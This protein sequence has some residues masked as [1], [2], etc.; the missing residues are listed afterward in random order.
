MIPLDAIIGAITSIANP[1]IKD[2]LQRSETV[3]KLLKQF[4][5]DPEHPLP[6][7]SSVYAY[8]LVE[9]GLGKPKPILE[10]FR[11]EEI[12]QAFREAFDRN[13]PAIFLKQGEEFLHSRALGDEI[14]DLGIDIRREFAAFSAVFIAVTKR[15]RT[16][17][18]ALTNHQIDSVNKQIV[19]LHERLDRLPTLEG[20]RTEMARLAVE[21]N[22]A[23]PAGNETAA[24]SQGFALA[25]QMRGWFEILGYDFE[26]YQV[27]EDS[28]FEWIIRIPVRRGR[29]DRILIRGMAGEAG[30]QDIEALQQSVEKQK[31]D[32]GWLVTAR[33][34]SKAAR[35][36]VDKP[37]N[38]HLDCYTF[39]E[40]IDIDAD[41][42]G[43]IEWLENEINR[44][45]ID[46]KY[47]PLGCTKAEFD[48]ANR[49]QI[50]ASYYG[51]E[52]GWIDGYIDLWMDDPAKEHIS[53]LGE[54]GTGK[55]WFAFHYAWTALQRYKQ[56]KERGTQRPRLPLIIT[57]RDYAKALNVENVLAG[58]FFTK[59][60]IR[61]NSEVFDQLN[62]MGKLLLIFDGFDEMAAKCDRQQ[63]INNFWELAKVIV[64]GAK[65]IL[66]CRTEHFPE[67]KEGRALLNAELQAS[68][69]N[70]TG[71]TPQFE[72][73]ELTAFDDDQIRLVLSHQADP[74]TVNQVMN[75]PQL[76]DLARRPVMAE[77]I[78]ESLPDIQAGKPVDMS[79]VY[80]YAVR[81]KMERD[82]KAE[83]TF[84]SLADKLFF[85]CE[86]SWEMLSTDQMSLNYRLFPDRIRRL[87]GAAVQAEKD[88]D[89]WH[90]DMM[91]QTMLIRN[92]EG[93]YSPAHRSLLEFFVAYKLAAEL[94][95]LPADFTEL[96]QAQ[97][98]LDSSVESVNYTWSGYFRR[99][100]D[101]AGEIVPI[102]ALKGFVSESLGQL[103][104]SFG[105]EILTKAVMDLLVPMLSKTEFVGEVKSRLL[106]I[107]EAT[108]GKTEEE[109]GY[110][111]GNAATVLVKVD[112]AALEGRDLSRAVIK[113]ADFSDASL[114]C[115]NFAGANLSDCNFTKLLGKVSSVAFS[116][117]DNTLATGDSSGMVR[118]WDTSSGREVL[119]LKGST[120][121]VY[122]VAF[123]PDGKMLASGSYDKTVRIWDLQK[124]KCLIFQGYT[125][126]VRSVTFSPDGKTL[127]TGSSEIKLWNIDTGECVKIFQGHKSWV[128]SVAFSPDGSIL[129]SGSYDST[130]KLWDV[131]TG[132][133]LITLQEHRSSVLAVTFS[134]DGKIL[135]SGSYD[136]SVK[137]WDIKTGE[138][139]KTLQG[140]TNAVWS[141]AF[142]PDGN[143]LASCGNDTIIRIWNI[144]S[145]EPCKALG[146]HSQKVYSVRFSSDNKILASGSHDGTIKIWD[147][148]TNECL[149]T[150]QGCTNWVCSIALNSSGRVVASGGGDK[151]VKLWDLETGE[152]IKVLQGHTNWVHSVALS[153]D[154]EMLAS[155]SSELRLWDLRTDKCLNTFQGHTDEVISV[156]FSPD[157]KIIASGSD[158]ETVKLWDINTGECLKTLRGHANR[159]WFVAFSP[160]G[161]ILAS[162]SA[163]QT[164]RIWNVHT[165]ECL[166]TLQ[167][168]KKR[169]YSVAFGS[170]GKMIA[171]VGDDKTVKIWDVCTGQCLKI[172]EGH[173]GVILAVAFSPDGNTIASGGDDKIVR[174]WDVHTGECLKN[175]QGHTNAVS[176]VVFNTKDY[177]LSSS[178][179]ETIKVWDTNTGEC[180]KTLIDR[181]YEGM[182]IT[183]VTGLTDA[184]KVTIASLG[185]VSDRPL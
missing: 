110:V 84:T 177:V 77:L 76:L 184:E 18:E 27:W 85:L 40:L 89:H 32:E 174:L 49:R 67:A 121:W 116:P 51:E 75:N 153:P 8:T 11:D 19:T 70:L 104:N 37:E 181:P 10:L 178:Y 73:L 149:N 123:S 50:D 23:L 183:G 134:P 35:R 2:K 60:N 65:V 151:M 21:N 108:K 69:A 173:T 168:H 166:K 131:S 144:H 83:R 87:F 14:K 42:S 165:G 115:V 169:V 92:A 114:R 175:L 142:S 55:T 24:K 136:S 41:F 180:L 106:E 80:L 16:P 159:V 22:P 182:N 34:I 26:P 128:Y 15:S 185:A 176:S 7:F 9:Y 13:S 163:D 33:R 127:A 56:A 95:V 38:R 58:F 63:T 91:G 17:K 160:D 54:F 1:I 112:N 68:T 124:D 64:P 96:S 53:V 52:D 28:Y 4:N 59:H 29:F 97:L 94:G 119:T 111:G 161:K 129:A 154:G 25:Q 125:D 43:Y 90:Y 145:D 126:W 74:E 105:R 66:T 138:C 3:I 46:G 78:L 143:V 179:D 120:S 133:C 162:S 31:T 20:I 155:V 61:L 140:H 139:L 102:P 103:R 148:S 57:L 99:E 12:K 170:E 48:S 72:V 117:N 86:L 88:L 164:V 141:V 6:D 81:R 156:T 158:D 98:Y 45:Q 118:F 167:G 79:R 36:E 47:V 130:V 62:R 107:L 132:K 152:R 171:S 100:A 147:V 122:S 93:D 39:D 146:G 44:R 135:A 157:G 82:I 150:I 101:N 172:L 71:E 109:V 137:L 113:G 30:I 5:L